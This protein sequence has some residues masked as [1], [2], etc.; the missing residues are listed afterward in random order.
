MIGRIITSLQ[1]ALAKLFRASFG[2][3][4][5][6]YVPGGPG[7]TL[8]R[9]IAHVSNSSALSWLN[10]MNEAMG[11][12]AEVA[13]HSRIRVPGHKDCRHIPMIDV[14]GN[15]DKALVERVRSE[16]G[17]L[18]TRASIFSSGQGVHVYFHTAIAP[19]AWH[20]FL[21]R[22]LL[23][24]PPVPS[25]PPVPVDVRWIGHSIQHR[26]SALRITRL[27]SEYRKIPRWLRDVQP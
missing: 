27:T 2:F 14:Q 21:G 4:F 23:W 20:D 24:T 25:G 8:S 12:Y 6:V 13:L 7:V 17:R 18:N 16:C 9:E 3:E 1:P 11:P 19:S 26:Y 10:E 15:M 5:S 22:L